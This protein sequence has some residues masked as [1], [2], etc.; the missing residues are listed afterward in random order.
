MIFILIPIIKRPNRTPKNRRPISIKKSPKIKRKQL[1]TNSNMIGSNISEYI[2]KIRQ[3]IKQS[4]SREDQQSRYYDCDDSGFNE[5][6][7]TSVLKSESTI[8]QTLDQSKIYDSR[9]FFL[10]EIFY[11]KPIKFLRSVLSLEKIEAGAGI[12]KSETMYLDKF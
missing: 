8:E 7:V 11:N 4:S 10:K 12:V 9:L 3:G 5:L 1:K 2:V 6:N